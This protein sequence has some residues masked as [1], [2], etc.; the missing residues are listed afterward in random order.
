MHRRQLIKYGTLAASGLAFAA[1]QNNKTPTTPTSQKPNLEKNQVKIGIVPLADAAPLIIAKDKGF[2]TNKG[3]QVELVL[4]NNWQEIK[5]GLA[6]GTLDTALASFAMPM[7]AQLSKQ[8]IPIISLMVLSL[9]GNAITLP[10][11]LWGTGI[12]PLIDYINFQEFAYSYSKYLKTFPKKVPFGID[13]QLSMNYYNL[14][15]WLSAMDI[16]PNE[17]V[18]FIEILP[19]EI[20][21]K[22]TSGIIDGYSIGEPWNQKAV[23]EK[24]GFTA[25]LSRDIWQGHPNTVLATMQSWIDAN[26]LTGKAIIA[27]VLEA[28]KFCDIFQEAKSDEEKQQK[29]FANRQ[30]IATTLTKSEYLNLA[31]QLLQPS[32]TGDY[33]YG[34][35]DDKN[36]IK[37]VRDFYVFNFQDTDYLKT[38]DRANYP[39]RSHGIWLLTQMVVGNLLNLREYPK[40]ADEKIDKIYPLKYYEEV[41]KNK[42]FKIELP[43]ERNKIEKANLFI[44]RRKFD[45]SDPVG[46]INSFDFRVNRPQ[47]FSVS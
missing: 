15:Y 7:E 17:R 21:D 1:C 39:W 43:K 16:N 3:L 5:K 4:K 19:A 25:C 33:N 13:S 18:D 26:P 23:L 41:A 38:P 36:R 44:D 28:C 12:R 10:P 27:A 6:D 9:N 40:D 47:I 14:R 29:L 2:F 20:N 45:P 32:L 11:K 31:P 22:L 42:A 34:G 35:F 37:Q 30:E 46:Y 24:S 8:E